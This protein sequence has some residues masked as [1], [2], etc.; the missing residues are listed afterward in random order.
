M[1]ADNKEQRVCVKFCFLL[2]N[3]AAE[4][5]LMLQEAF[6]EEALSKT[7]VYEWYSQFKGGEMSCEDQPISGRPSTCRKDENL[8][9]VRNPINADRRRTI[10]EISEVT[11]LSWSSRQQMLTEDLNTKR[12]SAKFVPQLL[13]EDQKN[14]RSNV[15][16]NFR[17]QAGNDPQILPK[18][19]TSDETWCY[20]YDP[21]TKQAS[22]QR[23]TPNSPKLKTARQV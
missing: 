4:T 3:S 10:D 1:M 5:V 9:K 11:G 16:Y 12:V 18:V 23:K 7:Q 14:N 13:T 15:C 17:E 22:S 6:E 19:V 8:E 2:G 20:G 21:E